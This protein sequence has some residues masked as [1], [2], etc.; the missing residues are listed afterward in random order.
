[1]EIV[2]KKADRIISISKNTKKDL[3]DFFNINPDKI[4]VIYHGFNLSNNRIYKRRIIDTFGKYILF[5]GARSLYKNFKVFAEAVSK[6]LKLEMG[7][8]LVCVGTPFT[9]DEKALLSKLRIEDQTIVLN[10]EDSTLYDLYSNALVFV[11]PSLY[12]GFGIPILEAFANN[13]PVCLSNTSSFP[14]VAGD[15]GV[16]FDPYD[17]ES[18]LEAVTK[19]L[20]DSNLKNQMIKAGKEHLAGYSWKKMAEETIVSY[21]KTLNI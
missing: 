2:I 18:I 3:V 14:E 20:Y 15:A 7:L 6:L 5:V 19:V 12:E 8:K 21:N 13:C 17:H 4:D 9:S 16:Y 10:V 1:M 11:Y